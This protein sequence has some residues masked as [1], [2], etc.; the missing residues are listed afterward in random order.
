MSSLNNM[1]REVSR[2]LQ[3]VQELPEL[4]AKMESDFQKKQTELN[5]W[6]DAANSYKTQLEIQGREEMRRRQRLIL[7]IN[8]FEDALADLV[9]A[10]EAHHI[11]H[12][13]PALLKAKQT[14]E[15]LATYKQP[16][17]LL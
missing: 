3:T 7:K 14:L 11:D 12:T 16:H 6:K 8:R 13:D 17:Y 9:E 4:L 5:G 15:E 10:Y 2:L 1:Q